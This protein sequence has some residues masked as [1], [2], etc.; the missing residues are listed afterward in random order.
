MT[1]VIVP[2]ATNATRRKYGIVAARAGA[3]RSEGMGKL[4]GFGR[5]CALHSPIP[6]APSVLGNSVPVDARRS[7]ARPHR[8]IKLDNQAA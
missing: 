6:R 4:V 8:A 7:A 2:P 5:V 1:S 3:G